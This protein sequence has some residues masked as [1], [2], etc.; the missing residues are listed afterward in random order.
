[1]DNGLI[2]PYPRMFAQDEAHDTNHPN[3]AVV[4]GP[5]SGERGA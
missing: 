5:V 2:F 4:F 1:M 3:L